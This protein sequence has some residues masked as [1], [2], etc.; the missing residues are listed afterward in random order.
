VFA[1]LF[2]FSGNR[3]IF[4]VIPVSMLV[5]SHFVAVVN[6]PQER[7]MRKAIR[8]VDTAHRAAE[9]AKVHTDASVRD[10][11]SERLQELADVLCRPG[12]SK[13]KIW[14]DLARATGL[15]YGQCERIWQ[16]EW[17]VIPGKVVRLLDSKLAELER[18]SNAAQET[19]RARHQAIKNYSSDPSLNTA[20][21]AAR[22]Q[23]ADGLD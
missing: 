14:G 8:A 17:K 16:K 13:K 19:L 1:R 2:L 9:A 7:D 22:D 10:E 11:M 21:I 15:S 18:K 12:D 6:V 3:K 23:Q 4:A 20:R 5:T